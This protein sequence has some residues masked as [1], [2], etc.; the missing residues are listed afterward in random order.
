[1]AAT[2]AGGPPE[3]PTVMKSGLRIGLV[4]ALGITVSIVPALYTEPTKQMG[5]GP[6]NRSEW[7]ILVQQ[8][9]SRPN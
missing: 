8:L 3:G 6:S 7:L 2:N 1:M 4:L 5:L 9:A